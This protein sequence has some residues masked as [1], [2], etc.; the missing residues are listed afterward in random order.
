MSKT[1]LFKYQVIIF[2]ALQYSCAVLTTS[3]I[4][5]VND[6]S[7]VSDSV[8]VAPSC[9]FEDLADVRKERGL[10]YASSLTSSETRFK[11]MSALAQASIDDEALVK[12]MDVYVNVLNS[13]LRSLRSISNEAR[14][15][16]TGREIRGIG[17]NIDSLLFV[18]NKVYPD[19]PVETGIAKQ[20]GKSTG[21]IAEELSKRRQALIVKKFVEQGDTLVS[22]CCDTLIELLKEK[23]V[24]ELIV[25]EE[26]GLDMNYKAYLSALELRG[27]YPKIEYDREYLVLKEELYNARKIRD[28]CVSSLR[29]LKK[30]HTKLLSEL[31]ERKQIDQLFREMMDLNEQALDIAQLLRSDT[32]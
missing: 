7:V 5:M 27:E 2:M 30:A 11:E 23:D 22:V 24:E 17:R 31:Q 14:W 26:I 20:L 18:Y 13:Y 1:A 3:Q 32:N 10:F 29:S 21:Y 6:L 25:N 9:F 8:A 4:E 16:D 28:K 19:D 15:Y 12:R